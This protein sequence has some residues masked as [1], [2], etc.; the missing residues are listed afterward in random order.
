ML[1]PH[2]PKIKRCYSTM[3]P[4]CA[5][6]SAWE[7]FWWRKIFKRSR[8]L[9]W[10]QQGWAQQVSPISSAAILPYDL[11]RDF[12]RKKHP[13]QSTPEPRRLKNLL[14]ALPVLELFWITAAKKYLAYT[15]RSAIA[16]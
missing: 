2:P 11:R 8:Q 14:R 9:Y 12:H 7:L 1:Q 10:K 3:S 5:A 13:A 16:T 6:N 4:F 15:V